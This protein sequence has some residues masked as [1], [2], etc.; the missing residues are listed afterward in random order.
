MYS[1]H[2]NAAVGNM[3]MPVVKQW[4]LKQLN[5]WGREVLYITYVMRKL[6]TYIATA[7]RLSNWSSLCTNEHYNAL[8]RYVQTWFVGGVG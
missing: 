4:S 3:Y 2:E 6:P 5:T 7:G 8:N 1:F